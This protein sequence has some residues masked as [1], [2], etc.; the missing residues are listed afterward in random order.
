MTTLTPQ[1]TMSVK[2]CIRHRPSGVVLS[3]AKA[4]SA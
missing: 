4:F 1:F 2:I 3:L